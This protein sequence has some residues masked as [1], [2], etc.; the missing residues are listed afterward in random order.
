[1]SL[2]LKNSMLIKK[3]CRCL[4]IGFRSFLDIFCN[5]LLAVLEESEDM[6]E[7]E[8]E[9]LTTEGKLTGERYISLDRCMTYSFIFF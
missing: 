2:F 5:S 9:D 8:D 3:T 1:M 4:F 6:C 7:S